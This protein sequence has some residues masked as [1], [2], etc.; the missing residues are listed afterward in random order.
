MQK[1]KYPKGRTWIK[2]FRSFWN[3]AKFYSYSRHGNQCQR[4]RQ[5]SPLKSVGRDLKTENPPPFFSAGWL[6]RGNFWSLVNGSPSLSSWWMTLTYWSCRPSP[7]GQPATPDGRA[8]Q[9]G[10]R[11]RA[12]RAMS[13]EVSRCHSWG[14]T[15]TIRM[16]SVT[17][18]KLITVSPA[19]WAT[20]T[21]QLQMN[22]IHL[23]KWQACR[24]VKEKRFSAIN[25]FCS[26]Q[27]SALHSMLCTIFR[28]SHTVTH[29]NK[30]ERW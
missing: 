27:C 12:G 24:S 9:A 22:G 15:N 5:A 7:A 6:Q 4:S 1:T 28:G 17:F 20:T 3:V 18:G 25:G 10:S 11:A 14:L 13:E 26:G 29:C 8:E 23:L 21:A 19:A 16:K 2:G 30:I